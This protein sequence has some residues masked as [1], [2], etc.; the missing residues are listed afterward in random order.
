MV[1]PSQ[2]FSVL[3]T[4]IEFSKKSEEMV[5]DFNELRMTCESIQNVLKGSALTY[6][7]VD[8]QKTLMS[9]LSEALNL[10]QSVKLPDTIAQ[11]FI[12]SIKSLLPGNKIAQIKEMTSKLLRYVQQIN[13]IILNVKLVEDPYRHPPTKKLKN[14]NLNSE[15]LTPTLNNELGPT[16]NSDLGPTLDSNNNNNLNK[17]IYEIVWNGSSE[18]ISKL[19]MNPNIKVVEGLEVPS[20]ESLPENKKKEVFSCG[21]GKFTIFKNP[22]FG[23]K[24][25]INIFNSLS[26]EHITLKVQKSKKIQKNL[27]DEMF[28]TCNNDDD[29]EEVVEENKNNSKKTCEKSADSKTKEKNEEKE[30]ENFELDFFVEDKSLNGTYIQKK[31]QTSWIRTIKNEDFYVEIGDLIGLVMLKEANNTEELKFSFGFYINKKIE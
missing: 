27:A 26:R 9:D 18:M 20:I 23:S 1:D 29:K 2:F 16:L 4:I 14:C 25:D 24:E 10:L 11:K 19:A 30:S 12:S 31:N 15:G 3:T 21:R 22:P 6:L 17:T 8:F 13:M 7:S 28:F 5:E